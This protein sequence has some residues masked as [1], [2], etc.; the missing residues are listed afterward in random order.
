VNA[1]TVEAL[2]AALLTLSPTDRARLAEL[3]I[4]KSTDQSKG[5]TP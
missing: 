1:G 5:T 4:G 3:L 2:A